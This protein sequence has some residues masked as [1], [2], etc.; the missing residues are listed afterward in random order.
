MVLDFPAVFERDDILAFRTM[1]WWGNFFSITLHLQGKYKEQYQHSIEQHL[2]RNKPAGLYLSCN[3]SAWEYHYGEDNYRAIETLDKTDISSLLN[4]NE[5]IKLS[6]KLE[7]A[8][9]AQL[10]GFMREW[11]GVLVRYVK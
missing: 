8:D 7:L 1:F 3:D 10:Q 4:K 5:F 2:H 6:A 11:F 9:Y